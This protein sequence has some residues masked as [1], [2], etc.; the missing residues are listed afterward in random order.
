[1][2]TWIQN[3]SVACLKEYSA[4]VPAP[5]NRSQ[6]VVG[7][8]EYELSGAWIK[9]QSAAIGLMLNFLPQYNQSEVGGEG[10]YLDQSEVDAIAAGKVQPTLDGITAKAEKQR[11]RDEELRRQQEERDRIAAEKVADQ[12]ERDVETKEEWKRFREEEKAEA[13]AKKEDEKARKAEE[14]RFREEEKRRKAKAPEAALAAEAERPM[15]SSEP[16]VLDPIPSVDPLDP[17]DEDI[18]RPQLRTTVTEEIRLQA[19]EEKR[20]SVLTEGSKLTEDTTEALPSS[21]HTDAEDVAIVTS[22]PLQASK[23]AKRVFSSPIVGPSEEIKVPFT[24]PGTTTSVKSKPITNP[25]AVA[26]EPLKA[27][28]VSTEAKSQEVEPVSDGDKKS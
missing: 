25:P 19:V 17:E 3:V 1:M 4:P 11:A 27:K 21:E 22:P 24:Q 28:P 5:L 2:V 20:K 13:R 10:K 16:P 14:K 9:E 12:K 18:T 26:A 8:A 23:V 15:T 6:G 7:V